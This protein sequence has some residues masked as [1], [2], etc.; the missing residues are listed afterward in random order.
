MA[1]LISKTIVITFLSLCISVSHALYEDASIIIDVDISIESLSPLSSETGSLNIANIVQSSFRHTNEDPAYYITS[2]H[3]IQSIWNISYFDD[4]GTFRY[5]G[6]LN[7]YFTS[8]S[9]YNLV[10][11]QY[12]QDTFSDDHSRRVFIALFESNIEE[13]LSTQLSAGGHDAEL[14]SHLSPHINDCR[15]FQGN[16]IMNY[17]K[18]HSQTTTTQSPP[19]IVPTESLTAKSAPTLTTKSFV[20][21]NLSWILMFGGLTMLICLCVTVLCFCST[22]HRHRWMALQRRQKWMESAKTKVSGQSAVSTPTP[23]EHGY[24]F[25]GD[26]NGNDS[27]DP[28][29]WTP[30]EVG[31]WLQRQELDDFVDVIGGAKINGRDL[32]TMRLS[33]DT[34]YEEEVLNLVQNVKHLRLISEGYSR[35]KMRNDVTS[36]EYDPDDTGNVMERKGLKSGHSSYSSSEDGHEAVDMQHAI[37]AEMESLRDERP[38]PKPPRRPTGHSYHGSLRVDDSVSMAS[39]MIVH[40]IDTQSSAPPVSVQEDSTSTTVT[41][42]LAVDREQRMRDIYN[43][44]SAVMDARSPLS[45]SYQIHQ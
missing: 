35:W 8:E 19:S 17:H 31:C 34:Q 18:M 6:I 22:Q 9:Q 11:E 44:N 38:T 45:E 7:V 28:F 3:T 40:D 21:D 13:E 26:S 4:D 10:V 25:N 29:G 32:L 42:R 37:S 24:E 27:G 14:Q 41:D 33:I 2:I 30:N 16:L 39:T 36:T 23:S 5:H 1:F 12:R 15:L 43:G 20:E